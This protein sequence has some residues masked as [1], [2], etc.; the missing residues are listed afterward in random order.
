MFVRPTVFTYED[1]NQFLLNPRAVEKICLLRKHCQSQRH[2]EPE[3][4]VQFIKVT[5]H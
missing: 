3:G 1:E 2:N 5:C 4:R